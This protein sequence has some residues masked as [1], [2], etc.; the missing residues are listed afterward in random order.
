MSSKKLIEMSPTKIKEICFVDS[1]MNNIA[2]LVVV[3][4]CILYCSCGYS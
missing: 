4:Y 1:C 3:L 2:A